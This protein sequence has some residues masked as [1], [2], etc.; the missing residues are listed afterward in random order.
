MSI[1]YEAKSRQLRW[2]AG[3]GVVIDLR[4]ENKSAA[5]FDFP[6]PMYRT[7]AQPH[8]ELSGPGGRKQEFRPDSLATDGDRR[9]PPTLVRIAPG[10]DWEGDLT[11]TLFADLH[12]PG[13]YILRS[14]IDNSGTRIDS[15]STEFDVVS[16]ATRDLVTEMSV[17]E[18]KR[19]GRR[20]R[21]A[22][23]R[24]TCGQQQPGGGRRP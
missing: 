15:P 17:A 23:R 19:E 18:A 3:S 7:S 24:R 20:L 16:A 1:T 9:R 4:I 8:F 14:W 10:G 21:G 22:A 6:D 5:P 12:S 11:V 13:H 2:L